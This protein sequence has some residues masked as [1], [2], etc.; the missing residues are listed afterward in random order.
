MARPQNPDGRYIRRDGQTNPEAFYDHREYLMRL[1]LQVPALTT[2]YLLTEDDRYA[3]HAAKHL[4]AWFVDE[5]TKTA[6]HLLYAQ[7]IVGRTKGRGTGIIDT[8]H[9]V[10]VAKAAQVFIEHDA[11]EDDL[12]KGV[13]AWF[14]AY[15]DWMI[16]HPNGKDEADTKNNHAT[17]YTMQVLSFASLV[18]EDKW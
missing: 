4:R 17:C 3:A 5:Q 18:G 14:A 1:S 16:T 10:E 12:V 6:P 2:A 11:L 15:L 13:R 9:L 8:I 7:A